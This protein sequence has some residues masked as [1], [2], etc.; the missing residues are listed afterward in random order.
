MLLAPCTV[1]AAAAWA[2]TPQ[3][4]LSVTPSSG[5]PG[6]AL[7]VEGTFFTTSEPVT[8]TVP[9]G[10]QTTTS[11]P[12]FS[13]TM[14][15][16]VVPP[17]TYFVVARSS[18]GQ[19]S[20]AIEVTAPPAP[21]VTDPPV[22]D[23]APA[24]PDPPSEQSAP[25]LP[26]LPSPELVSMPALLAPAILRPTAAQQTVPASPSGFVEL[27]CGRAGD[28]AVTGTCGATSTR[29]AAGGKRPLLALPARAFSARPGSSI[30]MRFHVARALLRRLET[31]RRLR[32][33][34]TVTAAGPLG[35]VTTRTFAF[36]LRAPRRGLASAQGT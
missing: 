8:I 10:V 2:C 6:T 24:Q 12:S 13:V 28:S 18:F 20:A 17:G 19:A 15:T 4:S 26:V 22:T 33:R 7:R 35:A 9:G 27:V 30:R 34:G 23:P 16:P 29:A 21:P 5:P 14:T 31:A 11:G 25:P 32:M 1:V 36:T 3:A